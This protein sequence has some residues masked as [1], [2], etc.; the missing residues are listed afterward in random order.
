MNKFLGLVLALTFFLPADIVLADINVNGQAKKMQLEKLASD[1]TSST[2]RIYY[3]TGTNLPKFYNGTSWLTV[4]D[5][6]TTIANPMNSAGD[7]IYGGASGTP[8]ELPAGTAGEW[9]VSGGAAIPDWTNTVTTQK[10]IAGSVD[11]DI[12]FQVKGSSGQSVDTAQIQDSAGTAVV[13]LE[14]TGVVRTASLI[15]GGSAGAATGELR[16]AELL[17]T[18][19]SGV[20]TAN[21]TNVR[22]DTQSAAATDDLDT[23]DTCTNGDIIYVRAANSAR[24]VV[25]KDGTGNIQTDGSVDF[26]LDNANDIWHGFCASGTWVEVSRSNNGA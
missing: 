9:L 16:G 6:S 10:I 15:A 13:E 21:Y 5:T 8:T 12:Q 2:S 3:N 17:T 19:A 20:I 7:M 4:A 11:G 24:T 22:V 14:N 23:I 18:I 1:P 25:I 26:S